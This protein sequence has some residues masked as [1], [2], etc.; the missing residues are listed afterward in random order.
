MKFIFFILFIF[1]SNSIFANNDND[2]DVEVINLHENKSLDQMVLENLNEEL[3]IEEISNETDEI[4]T[5]EVE[6]SQIDFEKK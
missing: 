2:S 4:S 5:T 1:F 3:E 6:V